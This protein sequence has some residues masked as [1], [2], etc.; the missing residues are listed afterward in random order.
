MGKPEK[1]RAVCRHEGGLSG[2]RN[3]M[4]LAVPEGQFFFSGNLVFGGPAGPE[5]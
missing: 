4:P 2:G 1:M 5:W 3:I